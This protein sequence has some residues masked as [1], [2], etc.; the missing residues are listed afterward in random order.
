MIGMA[1]V[2]ASFL[3]TYG[4]CALVQIDASAAVLAAVLALSLS[5]RAERTDRET[6]RLRLISLPAVGLAAAGVALV[7]HWNPWTGA[8]LFCGGMF[9]SIWLRKFGER[10]AAIGTM[11]AL[12][13]IA[14]LVVPVRVVSGYG[15]WADIVLVMA[16]AV[17]AVLVCALAGR[18]EK[19]PPVEHALP[20]RKPDDSKMPVSTRM[21]L[22]MLVALALAFTIG[23]LAFPH[24]WGW[25]VLTAFIV[26]SGARGR[27]DALY[28]GLLRLGG[29]IGGTL[30]ASLVPHVALP[31]PEIAAVVIFAVLFLGMWLRRINYAYWAACATLIFALLQPPVAGEALPL[32]ATRLAAILIGAICAVAAAWFVYPIETESVIRRALA[33][34]LAALGELLASGPDDPERARKRAHFEHRAAAL[35]RVAPPV[36]LHRLV[37]PRADRDE[38]PASWIETAHALFDHGRALADR[39]EPPAGERVARAI[40]ASRRAIKERTGIGAALRRLHDLLTQATAPRR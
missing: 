5:R 33:D 17:I 40:G 24:H 15:A 9:L 14:M 10:Q 21:A 22:Q 18:L 35:E 31:N 8:A 13:F 25:L 38:H 4:L 34:A 37:N 3:L 39:G 26:C 32:L 23:L 11:I 30:V 29:A 27:G 7:L 19:V 36:R 6:L 20:A 16:A 2:L 28:K 1:A 12:P